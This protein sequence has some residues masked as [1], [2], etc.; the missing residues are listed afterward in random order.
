MEFRDLV[1]EDKKWIDELLSLEDNMGSEFCFAN[2]FNWREVYNIQIARYKD[3][4]VLR[5][6]GR[7]KNYLIPFGK[8]DLRE[9]VLELVAQSEREGV[10]FGMFGISEEKKE[11]LDE[12]MPD[13]LSFERQRDYEDYIY[14][15]EKLSSLS[16][17]KLH[18][19][20]NHIN[21]FLE[22]NPHW[23]YVSL[24]S[25]NLSLAIEM[26]E[27]WCLENDVSSDKEKSEEQACVKNAF[28]HFDEL[29]L[30]GGMIISK[31]EVLGFSIGE[32][33]SKDTFVVHIE[34]AFSSVRGAYPMINREFVR[35]ECKGYT[36]I[37]REEDAGSEGLR[38]AK[39]SYYP[40]I[41]LPKYYAR[42]K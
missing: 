12:L 16:G 9:V 34:K 33:L 20:R 24:N 14:L 1:L 36:Y 38:K 18:S 2:N 26:N 37:N 11:L 15:S 6:N 29:G 31:G 42:L 27:K 35:H 13:M 21:A 3:F 22:E 10:P 17:K 28:R 7:Q 25:S 23:Q 4:G 5:N 39:L 30:K 19:K 8:G 40:E 41:I 32:P